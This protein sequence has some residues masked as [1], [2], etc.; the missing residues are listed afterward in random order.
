MKITFTQKEIIEQLRAR[1]TE[2]FPGVR[3]FVQYD[4]TQESGFE[5]EFSTDDPDANISEL[6]AMCAS[7]KLTKAF[8]KTL[9]DLDRE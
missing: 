3:L 7:E 1:V 8:A 4:H 5:V 6:D 9:R 2:W